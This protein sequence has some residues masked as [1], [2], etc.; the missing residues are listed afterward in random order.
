[1]GTP[2]L[3]RAIELKGYPKENQKRF[4]DFLNRGEPPCDY[5]RQLLQEHQK[6]MDAIFHGK[7]VPPYEVEIQPSSSCNLRCKHCFGN[8]LTSKRIPNKI[9]IKEINKIANEIEGF[10]ENGFEIEVVKLCGTTGEPL[11]NPVSLYA[12]H[13]FKKLGKKVIFFTNGLWLDKELDGKKYLDYILEAD[14]LRLSLDCGSEETFIKLKGKPGFHRTIDSIRELLEKREE[15]KRNLKVIIGY[16]IGEKN[17]HEIVPAT[18][19]MRDLNVDEIR[20]RVDFTNPKGIHR[21]SDSIT[22]KLKKSQELQTKK[23]KVIS[24][25]S[26][27]EIE[28]DDS[29][30]YSCGRKCF[31]QHFWAC[32]GPDCNLYACGHRTYYE[33]E[34]YGNLLENSFRELWTNEKR[35]KALAK[36]PDEYCKFCSPSSTRRNEFMTFLHNLRDKIFSIL[37]NIPNKNNI[38][39]R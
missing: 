10:R 22:A 33:V 18:R 23:F 3:A 24:E 36:L 35:L 30:F 6:R 21:I 20:F 13:L 38:E 11:V 26:K 39:K 34:P 4:R 14:T 19:L 31:N 1:M 28:E 37:Q 25:Y 16:V 7:I 15:T 8:A 32:I 29:A 27:K 17:Y 2:V 9:G 5:E 12:I